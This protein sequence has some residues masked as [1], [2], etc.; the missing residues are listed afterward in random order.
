MATVKGDVHDIGKNIVGVVMGCNGYEVIDLGVMVASDKILTKAKDEKV[1]IIGLSGLITPSLD[2]MVHVA[3]EMERQNFKIPLLIGGATTS[4]KHTAVKIEEN[5]SGPTIH[6]ID[7]SRAIGVVGKLMNENEKNTYVNSIKSDYD[8]IRNNINSKN[9]KSLSIEDARKRKPKFNWDKYKIHE[10]QYKGITVFNDFQLDK[11]VQYIDWSPFF[12]AWEMKGS[13]PKILQSSRYGIEAQKVFE[14]GKIILNK[15]ISDK[16]LKAKGVIGIFPAF[17][18]EE[19]VFTEGFEFKFPRQT[20]DKGKNSNQYC[21]ADFISPKTDYIGLFAVTAGH[22][23]KKV[24]EEFESKNDDY[25]AIMVKIIADRLVEAFAECMHEKIRTE[26]WGYAKNESFTNTELLKEKYQGI[27][28][29]PGYPSCPNHTEKD[30][31]WNILNVENNVNIS[32]TENKAMYP[33]ASIC[34]WYF[35]H[36]NSKYFSVGN[37]L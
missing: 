27:R 33:A 13:Y 16:S 31:I 25:N 6:V 23:V 26:I 37:L 24:A 28:P 1:D 2:E 15:I 20:I 12:H 9:I 30:K 11:L 35:S 19:S 32:L 17:S 36:P 22:G 8:E 4:R 10:P 7:A 5:Y 3:Q 29:A 21:L 18:V 34:G 14:D